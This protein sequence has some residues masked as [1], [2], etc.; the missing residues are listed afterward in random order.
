M[1]LANT[2]EAHE[3]SRSSQTQ[4]AF[5]HRALRPDSEQKPTRLVEAP[6]ASRSLTV[7]RSPNSKREHVFRN[8]RTAFTAKPGLQS[9]PPW[10]FALARVGLIQK[11]QP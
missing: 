3:N 1:T 5:P 2:E 9:G 11:E 8:M 6:K 4:H 10:P 7:S